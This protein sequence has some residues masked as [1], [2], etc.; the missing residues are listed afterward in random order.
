MFTLAHLSDLHIAP[1][2]AATLTA[3]LNKR[4]LGYLSWHRKRIAEHRIEVLEALTADLTAQA[5]DHIAVTGDLTNI[6]L[7][8]EFTTAARWLHALGRAETV[9]VVPGNHD[10]YVRMHWRDSLA[11]WLPFMGGEDT[12]G[13]EPDDIRDPFPFVRW[14]DRIAFVGVSSALPTAPLMASGEVGRSQRDRL[15]K[16]LATLGKKG[17]FRVVLVHHPPQP[18]AIRLRQGLTDAAAVR[19]VLARAGAELVLHGHAHRPMVSEV[20][21]PAGPIPVLGAASA[22]A[23][24]AS[25][26]GPGQYQLI[27]LSVHGDEPA[28]TVERRQYD[29]ERH[30]FVRKD[31][32]GV[33]SPWYRSRIFER[34]VAG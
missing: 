10:T 17:A 12:G 28:V 9:S 2:P 21:G 26:R 23:V 3:L 34:A 27:R 31:T 15:E 11:H 29:P 30:A 7:P 24:G 32:L 6:A 14:R 25:R 4:F 22:S 1:L 18:G 13:Y 19:H 33:A 5:P 20:P 8:E 16:V